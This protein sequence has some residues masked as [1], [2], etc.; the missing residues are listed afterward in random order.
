MKIALISPERRFSTNI[1]QLHELYDK[2]SGLR[3]YLRLWY[4]ISPSPAL[5]ILASLTP[6]SCDVKFVDENIEDID[7]SVHYDLVGISGMTS[8]APRIYQI[9]EKFRAYG[10]VVV[11]GGIHATVLPE[12][13]KNYAD[14]VVIGEAEYLWPDIIHDVQKGR[15]K[16]F[17]RS[18]EPIDMKHS[19]IPKY[20]LFTPG[21]YPIVSVQTSRGCPHDCNFCV[22]SKVYGQKYRVK[23]IEQVLE[24]VACIRKYLRS[25][26]VLFADDN[27]FATREYAKRLL[28]ELIPMRIRWLG[29][30]D[31]SI[32]NDPELL[33][34]MKQSGCVSI[35][36][37]LESLSADTLRTVD[38]HGWKF[39]QLSNYS[40]YVRRIQDHGIGVV[41]SFVAGFDND[42]IQIFDDIENFVIDNDLLA[43]IVLILSPLPGS[44]LRKTWE[45]QGRYM[46]SDW[47]EYTLEN[48]TFI[49]KLISSVEFKDRLARLYEK[50]YSD[51]VSLK[52]TKYFC[53]VMV[54]RRRK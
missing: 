5:P 50:I 11:V 36:I 6:D 4:G 54:N 20:E 39:R 25:T 42:T 48:L 28:R 51:E 18:K 3:T 52:R 40:A 33:E 22:A 45:Q 13:V 27:L 31:I 9:A 44:R 17:Y 19:P 53:D 41:G 49:P 21:N 7:F 30:S 8:Q 35:Y 47:S 15:I 14:S 34:L 2:L 12:E 43:A 46:S 10:V 38:R 37:G 29:T 1:P 16:P 26:H 32:A 23:D 24:E